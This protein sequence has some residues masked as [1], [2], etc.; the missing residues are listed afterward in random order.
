M[1]HKGR[2]V[3]TPQPLLVWRIGRYP[4]YTPDVRIAAS[5]VVAFRPGCNYRIRAL[6]EISMKWG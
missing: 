4:A 2:D 5:S 6:C 3:F 1:H